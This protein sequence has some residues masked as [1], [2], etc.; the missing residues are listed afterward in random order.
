MP[1]DLEMHLKLTNLEISDLLKCGN[2]DSSRFL[3]WGEGGKGSPIF[4]LLDQSLPF[5]SHSNISI[6]FVQS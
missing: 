1:V 5:L 4:N 6:T 2:A 3:T